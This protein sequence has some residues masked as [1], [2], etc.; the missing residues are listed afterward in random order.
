MTFSRSDEAWKFWLIFGDQRGFDVR[1]IFE[2][3]S[4]ID[5]KAN[6]IRFVYLS[7]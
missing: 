1:K 3:K 7:I 4:K 5:G 6:S 2:N